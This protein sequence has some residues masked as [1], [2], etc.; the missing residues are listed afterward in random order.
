MPFIARLN[1]W[2]NGHLMSLGTIA[3]ILSPKL[4]VRIRVIPQGRYTKD[5]FG[6]Q[7]FQ[8]LYPSL[9]GGLSYVININTILI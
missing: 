9:P 1:K 2:F 7:A 5:Y 4:L 3:V 6:P 8:E